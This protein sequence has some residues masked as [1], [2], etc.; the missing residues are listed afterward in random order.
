MRLGLL[1]LFP[2]TLM[3]RLAA[4][5]GLSVL[6]SGCGTNRPPSPPP[7]SLDEEGSA[8][9][10]QALTT[11]SLFA[12]A[13]EGDPQ[14]I[15][16][17]QSLLLNSSLKSAVLAHLF[18]SWTDASDPESL[19]PFFLLWPLSTLGFPW[20]TSTAPPSASSAM[21]PDQP[22]LWTPSSPP[23]WWVY[24]DLQ[25]PEP[26]D[27]LSET[28]RAADPV[29]VDLRA[30]PDDQ[31]WLALVSPLIE[32]IGA[33]NIVYGEY[34]EDPVTPFV[35]FRVALCSDAEQR[36]Y[37]EF[38]NISFFRRADGSGMA[39]LLESPSRSLLVVH[40]DPRRAFLTATDKLG[41]FP[42]DS[43]QIA[44]T[45]SSYTRVGDLSS[46]DLPRIDTP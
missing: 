25:D 9:E 44:E 39:L 35:E 42:G 29:V 10:R 27:W 40:A 2:Y 18:T 8:L 36:L 14:A 3:Q 16:A 1:P 33:W 11:E 37:E 17:V 5:M 43:A 15:Q 26:E 28:L 38:N 19:K 22:F 41:L 46:L 45:L 6:F 31:K 30:Q 7:S 32:P 21:P 20:S 12:R 4:L 24:Q 23:G 34:P 13:R